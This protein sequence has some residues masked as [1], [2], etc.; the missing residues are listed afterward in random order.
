M[1]SGPARAIRHATRGISSPSRGRSASGESARSRASST[2]RT[3]SPPIRSRNGSTV[4][5]AWRRGRWSFPGRGI[6]LDQVLKRFQPTSKAK[7]V[8]FETVYRPEEM[9]GQ[10]RGFLDWPYV[11]GLRIDEAMHPLTLLAVGIY[12]EELPN[13]NGAPVRIVAPWKYGYKSIKSIVSNQLHRAGAADHLERPGTPR[14]RVLLER[15]PGAV[16][17]PLEPE[18]GAPARGGAVREEDTD[19]QVQRLRG[20]GRIPLRR[21]GSHPAPLRTEPWRAPPPCSA[22]ARISHRFSSHT[23]K[24]RRIFRAWCS[25]EKLSEFFGS[26]RQDA[27]EMWGPRRGFH[28]SK[29]HGKPWIFPYLQETGEICGQTSRG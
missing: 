10:R 19:A 9:P 8:A 5:A 11:E 3:S 28:I 17:P 27:A 12:G 25:P 15:Q 2:T 21:N 1:S 24:I 26:G 6:Q 16:P 7:Y 4:S 14:V 18:A 22:L 13:Q 20:R 23:R 29:S